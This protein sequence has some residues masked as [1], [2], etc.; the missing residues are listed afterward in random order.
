MSIRHAVLIA[1][2]AY[3]LVLLASPA[4]GQDTAAEKWQSVAKTDTQE[5]FVKAGSIVAIGAQLE[6][7]VKQNYVQAQ[8]AAK[9]G[10]SYLSS[11]TT[12][13]FDCTQRRVAMK[14]VRAF[15]G[16]DLQGGE[17]QKATSSDKNLIWL[18]AAP[19][20][21]FGE[22]LDHVCKATPAAPAG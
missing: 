3:A 14:D 16:S 12:Y 17:V 8:P 5:V 7:R 1:A 21:V 10:K 13:R 11:R 22:L 2:G 19:K 9:A 20:T 15:A 4:S 18:D 6:A